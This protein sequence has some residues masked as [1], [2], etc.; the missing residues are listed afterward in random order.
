MDS[1]ILPPQV[2]L[3]DIEPDKFGGRFT[4]RVLLPD[5]SQSLATRLMLE[6]LALPS[7]PNGAGADHCESAR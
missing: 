5:S 6:D 1:H 3:Y 2:V 7:G 4:A